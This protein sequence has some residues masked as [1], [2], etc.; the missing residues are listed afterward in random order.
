MS[1][2]KPSSSFTGASTEFELAGLTT[3]HLSL[4]SLAEDIKRLQSSGAEALE[5]S[6]KNILGNDSGK[7][8]ALVSKMKGGRIDCE[9]HPL[10]L[11]MLRCSSLSDAR[12]LPNQSSS[13][14][15]VSSS[16]ATSCTPTG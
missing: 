4:I 13:T 14:T 11:P 10:L 9:Q 2:G 16:T 3:S 7:L 5:A 12:T 8:W 15:L 1:E 6:S